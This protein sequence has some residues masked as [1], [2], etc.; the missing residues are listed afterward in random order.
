MHLLE[1][2]EILSV[3]SGKMLDLVGEYCI[4]LGLLP[5]LGASAVFALG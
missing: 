3:L 5:P 1:T 4:S 2:V